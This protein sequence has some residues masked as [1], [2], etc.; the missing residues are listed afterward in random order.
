LELSNVAWVTESLHGS[1]NPDIKGIT[2]I[3]TRGNA[4]LFFS[5]KG[6]Y[7]V[8]RSLAETLNEF[9]TVVIGTDLD[10]EGTK[11]ATVI[12]D[13]LTRPKNVVRAAFTGSGY[14]KVSDFYTSSEMKAVEEKTRLSREISSFFKKRGA[15]LNLT[16]AVA[17]G[18]IAQGIPSSVKVKRGKTATVTAVVKGQ[19]KGKGALAVM[20]RLQ[21]AYASGLIDYPRVE[22]DY[23]PPDDRYQVYA[24]PELTSLGYSDEFVS[25]IEADELP[26][27]LKTALLFLE[28]ERLI[29]PAYVPIVQNTLEEFFNEDLTPKPEKKHI[30]EECRKIADDYS[31]EYRN[32]LY[33]TSPN[34]PLVPVPRPRKNTK[35]DAEEFIQKL[36]DSQKKA[37]EL[38]EEERK[39]RQ[40]EEF[41]RFQWK[42]FKA[43]KEKE[44]KAITPKQPLDRESGGAEIELGM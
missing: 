30:V 13:S 22:A 40:V 1:H 27:N 10:R 29:T 5:D 3:S 12:R 37:L 6:G 35:K 28:E 16:T 23:F 9:D 33:G 19:L 36:I 14:A 17:V 38:A 32:Y 26:L 2:L 25:P 44:K 39:K 15:N 11:L 21:S 42:H 7:K 43:L 18:R 4:P 24:H 8:S 20:K 34:L 31:L 41:N